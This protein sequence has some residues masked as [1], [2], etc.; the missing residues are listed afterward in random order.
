M[1]RSFVRSFARSLT[2][3]RFCYLMS[4][5][6][7]TYNTH[8]HIES[9]KKKM[10]NDFKLLSEPSRF[11]I[12]WFNLHQYYLDIA[13]ANSPQISCSSPNDDSDDDDDD[14]RNNRRMLKRW[15]LFLLVLLTLDM[16]IDIGIDSLGAKHMIW[17]VVF[18]L[19]FSFLFAAVFRHWL[20]LQLSR[21]YIQWARS[22]ARSYTYTYTHNT[23]T[24][25]MK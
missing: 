17:F 22:F 24:I 7:T 1:I 23:F 21:P 11:Q 18:L 16:R 10:S 8:T 5:E 13:M 3:T 20:W 9:R 15:S 14:D 2:Y 12:N 25:Y 4:N 19:S 6:R